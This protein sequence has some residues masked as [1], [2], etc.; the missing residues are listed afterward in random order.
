MS[1]PDALKRKVKAA[2]RARKVRKLLDHK[3]APLTLEERIVKA[4]INFT[5]ACRELDLVV[6][7]KADRKANVRAMR[8]HDQTLK[9]LIE[10]T[11]LLI[12]K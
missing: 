6:F 7:E 2:R 11:G 10:T 9:D 12:D 8:V 1:K 5:K 3:P 4:A